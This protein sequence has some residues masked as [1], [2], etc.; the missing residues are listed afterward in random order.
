MFRPIAAFAVVLLAIGC[1]AKDAGTVEPATYAASVCSGLVGWRDGVAADSQ[2][3]TQSLSGA[4]DVGTVRARYTRF[5]SAT[6]RR[7]DQLI[8]MVKDAGAPKA[9]H[10]LGYSRDLTAQLERTRTGLDAAQTSFAALPIGNL[11]AY[12]AGAR[13]IRDSLRGVF[14]RVGT[15]LDQLGRTYTSTDLNRAFGDEP[16]CQRLSGS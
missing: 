2:Q 15:T 10:G 12:A 16:A 11:S 5:F 7:T 6:V 14:A 4:A 9:D 1:G 3:L 13:R 8:G